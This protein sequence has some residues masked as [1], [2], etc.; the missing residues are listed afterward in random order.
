MKPT[1]GT[2]FLLAS[3]TLAAQAW[4]TTL[5]DACGND[6]VKFDVSTQKDQPAPGTPAEGKAQIVFVET[7]EKENLAFCVG[8][9]VVARLGLD[10]AW[11][12][13][14]KGNSY[15]AYS[16]EPG[17]H[18]LCTNWESPMAFLAKKVGMASFIAEPGKVYYF[19][20]RF[21][22][23]MVDIDTAEMEQRLDLTQLSADEAKYRMKISALSTSQPK[24]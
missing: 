9:D 21:L 13:A 7:I 23:K 20:A 5:P 19:Q 2:V 12:G 18:H 14:N 15:F 17:E 24:K 6:K 4:A 8:C 1:L 11:V 22:M 16:V 3:M 10:G